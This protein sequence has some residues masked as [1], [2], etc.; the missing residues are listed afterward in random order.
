MEVFIYREIQQ[1]I[2]DGFSTLLPTMDAVRI[3]GE[4]PKLSRIVV[5]PEAHRRLGLI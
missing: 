4:K 5:V 3:F 1:R 2:H